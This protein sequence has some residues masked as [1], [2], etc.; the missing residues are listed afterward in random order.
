MT[1][2]AHTTSSRGWL[3]GAL[4][5]ALLPTLASGVA[6]QAGG[7]GATGK[8]EA[9]GSSGATGSTAASGAAG[10]AGGAT[11]ASGAAGAT[12][13][14]G[15]TGA[16]G[17]T[18]AKAAPAGPAEK[19][20]LADFNKAFKSRKAPERAA[21]ITALGDMSRALP[22][23]G[24][25][26]PVAKALTQGLSDED[27]EVR[28]AAVGQ[29]AWGR[30]VD[31]VMSGFKEMIDDQR[32]QIEKRITRPDPES[33]DYVGRGARLFGDACFALANYRDDRA[34]SILTDEIKAL[35]PN[36]DG[37]N[38]STRLVGDLARALLSLGTADAVEATVQQT[39]AYSEDDGYQEPAAQA[40]HAAL[41]E[42][43]TAKGIAPPEYNKLVY[44]AWH[45]WF[46]ANSKLFPKKL[47]KL[48]APPTSATAEKMS[49][50]TPPARNAPAPR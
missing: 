1:T 38:L 42:F 39:Q 32:K 41:A 47:G 17:A 33:R 12:G 3:A 8:P 44:V 10:G 5:A 29:L 45:D 2:Q 27:L 22:D 16:S 37:N 36:T 40:L 14:T 43:S 13:A 21:A 26:K 48:D 49:M 31:T 18:G 23:K 34:A 30:Q 19:D 4:L 28:S 15:A 11:G 6:A 35:R 50:D 25:S 24:A 46:Q 7:A 9:T 20:L